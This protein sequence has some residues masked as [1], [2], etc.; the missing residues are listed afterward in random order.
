MK[1][2]HL[3][4]SLT[5]LYCSAFCANA[6]HT[7]NESITVNIEILSNH[8]A[9][10]MQTLQSFMQGI[11]CCV[12]E[13]RFQEHSSRIHVNL[14][15]KDF[16]ALNALLPSLGSVSNRSEKRI[17]NTEK[18]TEKTQELQFLQQK[19]DS[20]TQILAKFDAD[21]D[22]YLKLW[23]ELQQIETD[24]RRIE[25]S[26]QSLQT[27][28]QIYAVELS[29]QDDVIVPSSSRVSFV[30]MP[31]FEY[32]LL[33][34][35]NPLSDFSQPLYQ[36]FSLKYILTR[37]KSFIN[38]GIFKNMEQAQGN[39]LTDM[40]MISF[41]QNFYSRYLGRGNRRFFNPY[42]G[43]MIGG[44]YA[45]GE[46]RTKSFAYILPEFGVEL[47]KS[48]Y[49]M[50][51]CKAQYLMPITKENKNLRGLMLSAALNFVF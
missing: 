19:R 1:L 23:R 12:E 21:S 37:G 29:L 20:Y 40:F 46:N 4:F 17:N 26:L 11:E 6:Q 38:L 27:S 3:L 49:V 35:E 14:S 45:S 28:Q 36:G 33:R 18:I 32:S 24:I 39:E 44:V 9:Q 25:T 47:Y 15:K 5:T 51:D 10:S 22:T 2:K 31:G 16:D 43:Y 13:Q 41:G 8:Y 30:N 42:T 50:L 34:V 48:R 7:I